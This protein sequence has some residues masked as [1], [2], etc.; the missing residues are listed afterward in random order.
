M[1]NLQIDLNC[2]LGEGGPND[3]ALL[4]C[5][6]S[7]NIA[8]G[9]HA[10]S[11]EIMRRTMEL[12]AAAGVGIGAHPGLSDPAGMGRREVSLAAP[13]ASDL[14][15]AQVALMKIVA[16]KIGLQLRHVKPHGALYNQAARDPALAE[17]VATAV[18]AVNPNL[19]LFALAGSCQV[20]AALAA[21]LRVARE[22]FAD[23]RYRSDGTLAPRTQPGAVIEDPAQAAAQALRLV[24]EH[25]LTTIDGAELTVPADTLCVHGD[26]P[27]ALAALRTIREVFERESVQIVMVA[28]ASK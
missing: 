26:S 27:N 6:T 5:V 22:A 15:F 13:D 7:A 23:R 18:R 24:K 10:G 20:E 16:Q 21:G 12:A 25:K 4:G 2:D 9:V 3:A 8:C 17:A 14:V 11:A 28:G 19:I 1:K